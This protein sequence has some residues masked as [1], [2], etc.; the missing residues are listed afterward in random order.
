M[1]ALRQYIEE[2]TEDAIL[3]QVNQWFAAA[4]GDHNQKG[5]AADKTAALLAKLNSDI[6]RDSYIQEIS[7]KHKLPKNALKETVR[8]ERDDMLDKEEAAEEQVNLPAWVGEEEKDQIMKTGFAERVQGPSTGYYFSDG[9]SNLVRQTN[10]VLKALYH[11]YSQNAAEN[12]RLLEVTNGM[13]TNI[14]EIGSKQALE[15]AAFKAALFAEGH[16]MPQASFSALHVIKIW[17]KLSAEF[18]KAY[19]LN[20]LGWQPEEGFFAFSDR[21]YRPALQGEQS[22]AISKY[23]EYGV[24]EI[25]GKYYLSPSLSRVNDQVRNTDNIYENDMY[26][27]YAESDI[28]FEAWAELMIGTYKQRGYFSIPFAVGTLF[29]DI[30]MKT[31]KL[32]LLLGYG[33]VQSGKSEW[34]E[35]LLYLFFSG[36]DSFGELYKPFNLN[37]GTE[38]SFW[39]YVERFANCPGVYNEFDP[40]SIAE[41]RFR[42]LKSIYDGEG[43]TKGQKDK[44]RAI[45]QKVTGSAILI[46]QY[47]PTHDDNS[48]LMR[49]LPVSF[50]SNEDRPDEQ[51]KAFERLKEQERKGLSGIICQLLD[52]RKEFQH[53][54]PESFARNRKLLDETLKEE[55]VRTPERILKNVS[56]MISVVELLSIKFKLPYTIDDFFSYSK[57]FTID[58]ANLIT[59]TSGISDFW[60]MVEF[61]LERSMIREGYDFIVQDC[62]KVTVTHDNKQNDDKIYTP[63]KKVLFLRLNTVHKLYMQ[64]TRRTSNKNGLNEATLKLYMK[65]QESFIGW[66]K[67]KRFKK[68][69]TSCYAFDYEAL[70]INLERAEDQEH[71]SEIVILQGMV[72]QECRPSVPDGTYT[73]RIKELITT[74]K[75]DGTTETNEIFY[76]CFIHDSDQHPSIFKDHKIQVIGRKQVLERYGNPVFNINIID[77]EVVTMHSQFERTLSMP[78]PD[79]TEELPF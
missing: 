11:I 13:T 60:D 78:S 1:S 42:A 7:K 18:K 48:V 74:K 26:L 21:T 3:W 45:T 23:N 54:F 59:S 72:S 46:G 68:G 69:N 56:C 62:D 44:N 33:P 10:Y 28:G 14:I 29:R 75:E 16:Y 40:N 53:Y 52:L 20:R 30:V 76:N 35:S 55:G 61:L 2:H 12:R 65:E 31:T 5:K 43:R 32:P 73:F 41:E 58:M 64:E 70:G 19:D 77:Y 24:A 27:K 63:D 51:I 37:Q 36:K 38:F 57:Q 34:A 6:T 71:E 9:G 22:G 15:P 67:Q 8:H 79:K 49:S 47:L 39:N 4:G 17:N 66:V 50:Q 25:D